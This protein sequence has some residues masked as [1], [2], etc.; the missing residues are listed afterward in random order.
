MESESFKIHDQSG[1]V[2]RQL[3]ITEFAHKTGNGQRPLV[4]V[5]AT[6]NPLTSLPVLRRSHDHYRDFRARLHAAA[7]ANRS[8]HCHQDR[9][10]MTTIAVLRR[11]SDLRQR[12]LPTGGDRARTDASHHR[13]QLA[14]ATL[15]DNLDQQTE[16]LSS[17]RRVINHLQRL[18]APMLTLY[19]SLNSP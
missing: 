14:T 9:Y 11:R 18:C 12:W 8:Y 4:V 10:I 2:V 15:N 5:I 6:A 13:T 1:V 3:P 7:S 16:L 19:A 17:A